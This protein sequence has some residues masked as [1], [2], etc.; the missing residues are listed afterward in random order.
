[1]TSNK[2]INGNHLEINFMPLDGNIDVVNS[3]EGVPTA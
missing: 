3:E 2:L 1:M